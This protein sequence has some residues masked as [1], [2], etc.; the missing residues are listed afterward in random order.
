MSNEANGQPLSLSLFMDQEIDAL[1][2]APKRE[3]L[4]PG[5]HIV[6]VKDV[7]TKK[8]KDKEA[9]LISFNY[10][11]TESLV[12][13]TDDLPKA[14]TVIEQMYSTET[15]GGLGA[16]KALLMP[17]KIPGVKTSEMLQALPGQ[18]FK[19][20]TNKRSWTDTASGEKREQWN[21]VGGLQKLG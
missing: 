7:Q 12:K 5:V 8:A 18:Q 14:Q 10:L 16:L 13:P 11:Q 19:I 17:I 3:Q 15:E 20:T 21:I 4:P 1:P 9:L 6:Q 2:D